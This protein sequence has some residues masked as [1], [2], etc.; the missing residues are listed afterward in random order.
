MAS[1]NINFLQCVNVPVPIA[2]LITNKMATY[3]ELDS[4]YSI[5][6]E[7]NMLEILQVSRYNENKLVEHQRKHDKRNRR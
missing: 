2:V 3:H 6:D 5:E 1:S 4:V 7:W